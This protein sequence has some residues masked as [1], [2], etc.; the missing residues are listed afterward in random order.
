MLIRFAALSMSGTV[1]LSLLP[2]GSLK[3]TAAMAVGL[4]AL[5]CW[6]E[7]ILAL[8]GTSLPLPFAAAPL[9]ATSLSL[10]EAERAACD[11]VAAIWG[12]AP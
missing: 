4:L 6:A 2:D 7:G 5:L 12:D 9:T 3:R 11:T 10:Q 8:L 1:I